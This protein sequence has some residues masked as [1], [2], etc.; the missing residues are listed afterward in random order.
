MTSDLR[1]EV[2]RKATFLFRAGQNTAEIARI[3]DIPE[4][5]ASR[6][7]LREREERIGRKC[8]AERPA[9]KHRPGSDRWRRAQ[10][11]WETGIYYP[12]FRQ[13]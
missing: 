12:P 6:I 13:T 10:E 1:T 8:L 2:A 9:S 11:A 7:I 4:R 3:L 5:D